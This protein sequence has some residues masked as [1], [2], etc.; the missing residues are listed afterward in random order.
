VKAPPVM[1]TRRRSMPG[2]LSRTASNRSIPET[3]AS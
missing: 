2:R 1:N 3:P